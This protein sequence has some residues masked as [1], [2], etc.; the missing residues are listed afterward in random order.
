MDLVDR[1]LLEL[2]SE[3]SRI[4]YT[5][6]ASI[7][8]VSEG[9][10]RLRIQKL[11]ASG[12]IMKFTIETTTKDLEALV[13]ISISSNFS[14]SKVAE[15]IMMVDGIKRMS[16]VA[17]QYDIYAIITGLDVASVNTS[18]DNIRSISGVENTHTLFV[19]RKWQ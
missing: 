13:L 18:I 5:K 16:E 2:L 1:K 4:T 19:L 11:L 10:V 6:L 12:V 3:D 8:G 14:T 17:G 15:Q 9:T 7:L